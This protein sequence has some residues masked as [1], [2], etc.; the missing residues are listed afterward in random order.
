MGKIIRQSECLVSS[1]NILESWTQLLS[2][3]SSAWACM[4]LLEKAGSGVNTSETHTIIE[5]STTY[6]EKART[7]T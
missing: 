3:V 6:A 2:N 4:A 1:K 7:L 5:L